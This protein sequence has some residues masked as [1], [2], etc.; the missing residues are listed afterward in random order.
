MSVWVGVI[1]SGVRYILGC[2]ALLYQTLFAKKIPI[3][4]HIKI[5]YFV[6]CQIRDAR[7]K[8]NSGLKSRRGSA[9]VSRGSRRELKSDDEKKTNSNTADVNVL[10]SAETDLPAESVPAEL[11]S[12]RMWE[13]VSD[14][15]E[16]SDSS[17][18][19]DLPTPPAATR[20][21]VVGNGLIQLSPS[22]P[23]VR[24]FSLGSDDRLEWKTNDDPSKY[25]WDSCDDFT[26]E[27]D[28]KRESVEDAGVSLTDVVDERPRR[29]VQLQNILPVFVFGV[30]K[31]GGRSVRFAVI[32][33]HELNSEY[34][35]LSRERSDG[36]VVSSADG[37]PCD[38]HLLTTSASGQVT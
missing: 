22:D 9:A 23:L 21:T 13:D 31:E 4:T 20:V 27:Q 8:K 24:R 17:Q 6:Y 5:S 28:C 36:E 2:L 7:L 38:N 25:Y 34:A 19:V 18:L 11:A 1:Y 14:V 10:Q 33:N 37:S 15:S 12:E 16:A 35:M 26:A 32:G 3:A 29:L 30:D